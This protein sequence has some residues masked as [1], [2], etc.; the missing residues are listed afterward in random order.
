MFARI[1]QIYLQLGGLEP[2]VIRFG[3]FAL[4]LLGAVILPN[5]PIGGDV[6]N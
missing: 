1:R 3:L 4:T 5:P 2:Q 6:G